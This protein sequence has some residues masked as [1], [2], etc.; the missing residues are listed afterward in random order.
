[1]DASCRKRPRVMTRQV[2]TIR[3][4]RND[5]RVSNVEL[6]PRVVA[7]ISYHGMTMKCDGTGK[8]IAHVAGERRVLARR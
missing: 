1:M 8:A 7:E 5:G 4:R 6:L 3:Y 2:A